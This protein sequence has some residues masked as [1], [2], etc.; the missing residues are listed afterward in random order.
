VYSATKLF[1]RRRYL[2]LGVLCGVYA[3]SFASASDFAQD[4]FRQVEEAGIPRVAHPP[5]GGLC[6]GLI[7]LCFPEVL[8]NGFQNV[9]AILQEGITLHY[10]I[11]CLCTIVAAKLV[12]TALCRGSGL[13]GGI[14][15]PSL[16]AGAAIGSA[17]GQILD[18]YFYRYT[19]IMV[20]PSQSFALVGM[21]ATLASVCGVPLTSVI[22][23]FELSQDYTVIAPLV[24]AV[25]VASAIA[26]P[27]ETPTPPG[28]SVVGF[29]GGLSRASNPWN[30]AGTLSTERD[31]ARE[32]PS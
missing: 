15:A 16:M 7:A 14:Y 27:K 17:Y 23:L 26:S 9:D 11:P 18:D 3:T 19:D 28:A 10:T 24:L 12:A 5:I 20:A 25:A 1:P 4:L 30:R 22:L 6:T 8:Y 29:G 31:G 13:V 2:P 32:T 21:A